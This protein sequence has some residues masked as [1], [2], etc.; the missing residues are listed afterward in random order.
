MSQ[1][2]LIIEAHTGPKSLCA[3]LALRYRE[4]ALAAG[5]EVRRLDLAAMAFDPI[6]RTGYEAPQPLEPGLQ[7]A[8]AA[9]L[10]AQHLIFVYP[11]WW[12]GMPALLKGFID[13]TFQSGFAFKYRSDSPFP[14]QLLKGRTA[15][16]LVTMDSPP[17]YYRFIN[18]APG[19][20]QMK[21]T[22][23]AF[24]GIKPVKVHSLGPVRGSSEAK[25]QAWLEL[26][27]RLGQ[28]RPGAP[29]TGARTA[30]PRQMAQP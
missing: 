7:E 6:L 11:T 28:D 1:H 24:C 15:E 19:H 10:W 13:R 18:G 4:G 27:T 20:K 29:K 3:A 9:L 8:Q 25:R 22:I 16:L 30:D 14:D 2:I 26:A 23:L 5:H 17:W 12:G 21:R